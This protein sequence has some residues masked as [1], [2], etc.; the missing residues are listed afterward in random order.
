MYCI[1]R[2]L[3][4]A[5]VPLK[6][7]SSGHKSFTFKNRKYEIT[8]HSNFNYKHFALIDCITHYLRS[9]VFNELYKKSDGDAP[10]HSARDIRILDDIKMYGSFVDKDFSKY[11]Y[12]NDD[13]IRS[14]PIFKTWNNG[15]E[16]FNFINETSKIEFEDFSYDYVSYDKVSNWFSYK[17][18]PILEK[19]NLFD[20]TLTK[21]QHGNNIYKIEFNSTFGK[22]FA[23]NTNVA[24]VYLVRDN[25]Y[26]LDGIGQS[27]YRF[28]GLF[29][30]CDIELEKIFELFEYEKIKENKGNLTKG[31]IKR[32]DKMKSLGLIEDYKFKYDVF[33]IKN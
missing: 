15:W 27:I 10:P 14:H 24:N 19:C 33:E 1:E 30:S 18:F 25:F 11:L 2:C 3:S 8:Y 22:L 21:K 31:M 5:L 23:Y 4:F 17:P 6:K 12:I 16:I 9:K 13:M 32:F 28:F 20:V 26:K 7:N 29:K